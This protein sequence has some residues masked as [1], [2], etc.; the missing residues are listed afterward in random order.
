[1]YIH[2]MHIHIDTGVCKEARLRRVNGARDS[3]LRRLLPIYT[4]THVP[5]HIYIYIYI[6]TRIHLFTY[7]HVPLDCDCNTKK[8][9][10]Q[11][12]TATLCNTL[13]G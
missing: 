1:M 8:M 5:I 6:C 9:C 11:I 7:V 13:G 10:H 4:Y 12:A 3:R 2:D